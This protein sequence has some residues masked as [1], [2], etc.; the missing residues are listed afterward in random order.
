MPETIEIATKKSSTTQLVEAL[1]RWLKP[2]DGETYNDW[3]ERFDAAERLCHTDLDAPDLLDRLEE[4]IK[5]YSNRN[6]SH[7]H[8][9]D[10]DEPFY[11]E[12]D[13]IVNTECFHCGWDV[14]QRVNC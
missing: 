4:A 10:C 7:S 3:S 12:E 6:R 1:S 2:L 9:P 8:C 11:E 13:R 14:S 5:P